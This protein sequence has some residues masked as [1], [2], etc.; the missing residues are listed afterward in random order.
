MGLKPPADGK[1]CPFQ[2]GRDALG[3]VVMSSRQVV[4][5]LGAGLQ[6]AAPPLA[7][8]GLA[9]AQSGADVLDGAAGSSFLTVRGNKLHFATENV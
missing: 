5:A 7:E 2:L 1:D 6:V 3:D 9:A 8:P 4:Q